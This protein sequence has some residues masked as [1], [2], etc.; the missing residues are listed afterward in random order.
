MP[1]RC[2]KAHLKT[3]I[4]L[5]F[6]AL[7]NLYYLAALSAF[8]IWGFFSLLLKPMQ[9]YPSTEILIFRIF[10]AGSILALGLLLMPDFRK[11]NINKFNLL[12]NNKKRKTIFATLGG[13]LL[14]TANWYFFIFSMNHI[15]IRCASYAYLVCPILTTVLAFFLLH[16]KLKSIQWLAVGLSGL[17]CLALAYGHFEDLAYSLVVAISYALYLITQRNNQD[18]DKLFILA[19][20]LIFSALIL[21]PFYRWWQETPPYEADFYLRIFIMAAFFTILPLWLNLYALK[22]VPSSAMGMMLYINPLLNFII[23]VSVFYEALS[24]EQVLSYVL[25]LAS[26]IIFNIPLWQK[27]KK[28]S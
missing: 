27:K 8:I 2:A 24:M 28:L 1:L 14:L 26:I 13:G 22:G 4:N 9:I 7:M 23:S 10:F 12:D 15:G 20:Q 5:N 16:E 18:L 19:V 21:I 11:R 3:A 25:I 17:S 6:A